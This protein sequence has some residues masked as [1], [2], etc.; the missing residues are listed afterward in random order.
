LRDPHTGKH[1]RR[2]EAY[3][4]LLAE[5]LK[6]SLEERNVLKIG[7]G[8]HDLG[9][10]VIADAVLNKPGKL[11]PAERELMMQA[12]LKGVSLAETFPDLGPVLPIIR[13]HQE[14]WDGSGHPDGLS[15]ENIPLLARIVGIA[16]AFDAMTTDQPY[17]QALSFDQAFAEIRSGAG[18]QFDPF[19]VE[20]FFQLRPYFDADSTPDSQDDR[21]TLVSRPTP[22]PGPESDERQL[23]HCSAI[24]LSQ[25][26]L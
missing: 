1:N 25:I 5:K 22:R 19:L 3:A 4:L 9:K 21:E 13:S 20:A 18:S 26:D 24:D 11:S 2:V 16:N 10:V 6:L 12:T 17:R 15:G 7:A 23:Q 14:R 8:L